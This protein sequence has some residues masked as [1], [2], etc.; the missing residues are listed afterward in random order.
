MRTHIVTEAVLSEFLKLK[1]S[2]CGDCVLFIDNHTHF[3]N[4]PSGYQK[5]K[6][7]DFD[8]E[9]DCFLFDEEIFETVTENMKNS[10]KSLKTQM[11][12]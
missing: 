6:L 2:N 5:L 1:N 4:S 12:T 9:F 10:L 11:M 7:L 3:I 8:E